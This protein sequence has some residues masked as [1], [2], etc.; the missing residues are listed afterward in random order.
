M[1]DTL[2]LKLKDRLYRAYTAAEPTEAD[3][4]VTAHVTEAKR[5]LELAGQKVIVVPDNMTIEIMPGLP[6]GIYIVNVDV[7]SLPPHKAQQYVEDVKARL[8][9]EM[10]GGMTFVFFA[11]TADGRGSNIEYL[12]NDPNCIY[13][14]NVD[15]GNMGTEKATL[16]LNAVKDALKATAPFDRL[17]CVFFPVN[18][19]GRGTT[20]EMLP[21]NSGDAE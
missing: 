4:K 18:A 9:K 17:N 1:Q 15:V 7:G 11:R 12:P 2:L 20:I 21:L 10:P 13:I 5:Q 8:L 6:D 19:D 3:L 14:F 16:H